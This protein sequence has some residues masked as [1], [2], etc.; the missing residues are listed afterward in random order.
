MPQAV[1][2]ASTYRETVLEGW[3][4]CSYKDL[5]DELGQITIHKIQKE[6]VWLFSCE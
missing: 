6:K 2:W 3:D 4:R 5:G 1:G